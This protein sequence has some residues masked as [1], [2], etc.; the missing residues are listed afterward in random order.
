MP[1]YRASTI[2][3]PTLDLL[4]PCGAAQAM[5]AMGLDLPDHAVS[6]PAPGQ[7]RRVRPVAAQA[8]HAPSLSPAMRAVQARRL[9]LSAAHAPSPASSCC[10]ATRSRIW[11][12]TKRAIVVTAADGADGR[13]RFAGDYLIAADGGR[14]LVRKQLD[15]PFRRLH[16]SRA[17]PRRR[18]ALRLQGAHAR[19][20]L[21]ELH[22]RSRRM[23]SAAR[24]PRHVAHH[25]AG[26][27]RDRAGRRDA[28][29]FAPGHL[30]E[31]A[32][33]GR[34]LRDRGQ[35]D[36]P[37]EPARRRALSQRA[38]VPRRR[39]GPHQQP[40]GRDGPQWRA[41]RRVEPDRPA[42]ARVARRGRRVAA[43]RLRAAAQA[44]GGQRDQCH[45]PAQ[46]A[47]PRGA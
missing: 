42:G 7:D 44:R 5:V 8:R 12:R 14:S 47:A 25:H 4:E 33:A 21:G 32:A 41:P 43:R 9:G 19:H 15:I 45:D 38:R 11:R 40:A 23:V 28:G 35:G 30:A 20:L 6:R 29:A 34:A 22:R 1:D 13:R 16:L 39:C 2:H 24:D 10:S 18:H 36:L 37:R 26:R 31:P 17:F 3:P 27:S 46:Q